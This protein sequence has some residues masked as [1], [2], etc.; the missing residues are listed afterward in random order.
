MQSRNILFTATVLVFALSLAAS[1]QDFSAALAAPS[2]GTAV[3]VPGSAARVDFNA[4]ANGAQSTASAYSS[5]R[6]KSE[7]TLQWGGW[8]TKDTTNTAIT[9]KATNASGLSAAY[10]YYFKP[11]LAAEGVFDY[12]RFAN[13]Y[14]NAGVPFAVQSNVYG[15]T[16]NLVFSMPSEGKVKP[17]FLAGGGVLAFRPTNNAGGVVPG[18]GNQNKGTF[19]F[20]G[21]VDYYVTDRIAIRGEYRGFLYHVPN[22]KLSTLDT[23][24]TTLT[25][26]PSIGIVFRF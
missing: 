2:D 23:N 11:W 1:A 3:S 13:K 22:F 15:Y 12:S 4:L 26:V 9:H 25:S 6:G 5:D 20:G 16:A 21:G 8:F 10:R 14:V 18:N 7:V 19:D 17:F 24:K